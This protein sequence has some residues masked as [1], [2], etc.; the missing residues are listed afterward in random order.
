MLYIITKRG[1]YIM[2]R[3]RREI[4]ELLAQVNDL[5]KLKIIYQFIRGI[6]SS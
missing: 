2:Q 6:L 4:A 1:Y 3:L 5:E